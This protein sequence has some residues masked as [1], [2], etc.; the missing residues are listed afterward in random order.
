M[1]VCQELCNHSDALL[2]LQSEDN[3]SASDFILESVFVLHR[4]SI[5]SPTFFA[6]NSDEVNP[7]LYPRGAGYLTRQGIDLCPS[8]GKRDLR[9]FS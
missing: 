1:C 3:P 7:R 9:F 4:H 8:V 2:F 6:P 5:R